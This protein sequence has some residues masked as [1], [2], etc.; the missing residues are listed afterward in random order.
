MPVGLHKKQWRDEGEDAKKTDDV[1]RPR[2][3]ESS[4]VGHG[5]C[6]KYEGRYPAVQS[7]PVDVYVLALA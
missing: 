6:H 2:Y 5:R 4:G 7:L 3:D 1:L